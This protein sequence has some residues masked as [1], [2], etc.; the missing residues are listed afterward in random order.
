MN[1]TSWLER[2]PLSWSEKRAMPLL[3]LG[4]KLV[5]EEGDAVA[6]V[7]EEGSAGDLAGFE[8]LEVQAGVQGTHRGYSGGKTNEANRVRRIPAREAVR[9]LRRAATLIHNLSLAHRAARRGSTRR[10]PGT[11]LRLRRGDMAGLLLLRWG[12]IEDGRASLHERPK[13]TAVAVRSLEIILQN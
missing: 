13:R 6:G 11:D 9:R 12:R 3:V 1:C 10:T 5:G 4:K 7:G 8:R 2:P